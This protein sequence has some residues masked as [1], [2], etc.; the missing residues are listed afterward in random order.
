MKPSR[1]TCPECNQEFDLEKIIPDDDYIS[2][3]KCKKK[4]RLTDFFEIRESEI[5]K[6]KNTILISKHYQPA[7]TWLRQKQDGVV[8]GA[9]TYNIFLGL[10]FIIFCGILFFF[11]GIAVYNE[12]DGFDLHYFL[13]GMFIASISTMV[14][15]IA[16]LFVIDKVE[17]GIGKETYIK[18]QQGFFGTKKPFDWNSVVE[19]YEKTI[20]V[21][22]K[23]ESFIIIKLAEKTFKDHNN[24][25]SN[26]ISCGNALPNKKRQ[27]LLNTLIEHYE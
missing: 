2:C 25:M 3:S 21:T 18:E 13:G 27:F 7:G 14:I 9:A 4:Y 22:G 8:F 19:I 11:A 12:G 17:F 16:S 15:L 10:F 26:E 5:E 6:N 1:T 20:K 24:K 23:K